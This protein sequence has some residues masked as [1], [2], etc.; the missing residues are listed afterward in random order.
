MSIRK[1]IIYLIC[2]A[3]EYI[4]RG[5]NHLN[6][7]LFDTVRWVPLLRR[8][9]VVSFYIRL[10]THPSHNTAQHAPSQDGSIKTLL[11]ELLKLQSYR[12]LFY[13]GE[14]NQA[15]KPFKKSS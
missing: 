11:S 6:Y 4:V 5:L 14:Y 2:S 1:V 9:R 3:I 10:P 15:I 7:A 12:T 8:A 13:Y